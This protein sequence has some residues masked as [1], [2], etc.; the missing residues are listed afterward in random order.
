MLSLF[1]TDLMY[2]VHNECI[3]ALTKLTK[4]LYI[5]SYDDLTRLTNLL[6]R[7]L[8]LIQGS[9]I[10]EKDEYESLLYDVFYNVLSKVERYG[11]LSIL[12]V[13]IFDRKEQS[14]IRSAK[15]FSRSLYVR[16]KFIFNETEFE[17]ELKQLL[18]IRRV[19]KQPLQIKNGG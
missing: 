19:E 8:R 12:D 14:T 4:R 17:L 1:D 16:K 10:D 13:A 5:N 9:I 6:Q 18:C 11:F 15:E 7:E 3:P 2:W